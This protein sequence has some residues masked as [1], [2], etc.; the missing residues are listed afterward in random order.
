MPNYTTV[1]LRQETKQQ[2]DSLKRENESHDETLQ[3]LLGQADGT[4][5]TATEIED[6]IE[7]KIAELESAQGRY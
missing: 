3:R 1:R 4:Y 7:R 5:L 2:I 6:L